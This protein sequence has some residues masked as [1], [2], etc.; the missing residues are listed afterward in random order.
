MRQTGEP[1]VEEILESIKQV[2]ARN[3]AA[4]VARANG[5]PTPG[6][7]DVLELGENDIAAA[8]AG[9]EASGGNPLAGELATGSMRRSLAALAAL[10]KADGDDLVGS[11]ALEAMARE[12][13]RP[14]L[15]EWLDRHLPAMVERL[16]ADE[17]ARIVG[18]RA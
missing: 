4:A 13:L 14:A 6:N 17:I 11:H 12:M 9:A 8:G 15:A 7:A 18:R 16:V 2:I 1:S 10:G 5:E 3:D